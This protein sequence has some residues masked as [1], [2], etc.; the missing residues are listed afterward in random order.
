MLGLVVEFLEDGDM[1]VKRTRPC[2]SILHSFRVLFLLLLQMASK[3]VDLAKRKH[4]S[5]SSASSDE[6]IPNI[7]KRFKKKD[8]KLEELIAII[9]SLKTRIDTLEGKPYKANARNADI[10]NKLKIIEEKVDNLT[11]S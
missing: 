7:P 2:Y 8:N 5:S 3:Q 10:M 1:V 9:S 11:K 4:Y 6:D